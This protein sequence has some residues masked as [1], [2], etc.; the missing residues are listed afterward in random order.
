[1]EIFADERPLKRSEVNIHE[2]LNHC[3]RLASAGFG[4]QAKFREEYDPSLP[5][6]FG[7]KNILIQLF[8][9]LL[10]NACEAL[11][12]EA[13]EIKITTSYRHGMSVKVGGSEDRLGL[14]LMISIQDNG[15]GIPNEL[16]DNL[17]D[18]FVT[19]KSTGTGLGLAFVAKA[20][21]DH[22]GFVEVES[23]PRLTNFRVI[24]PKFEPKIFPSTSDHPFQE[25]LNPG[26]FP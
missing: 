5:P 3:V 9:N 23:M 11:T 18:P 24:L 21:S 16:I 12:K 20:I 4:N 25:Y 15:I 17:F 2:I 26:E 8:L 10:K 14:P 13:G 6:T 7:N 19:T 22:G 1:M